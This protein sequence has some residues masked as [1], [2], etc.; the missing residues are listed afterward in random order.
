MFGLSQLYQLRGPG[1]PEPSPGILLPGG[2][3][4]DHGRSGEAAPD[5]GAPHRAGQRLRH[6]HEGPGAA[7]RRQHPGRGPVGPRP[8]GG[9][10]HLHAPAGEDRG[11]ALRGEEAREAFPRPTCPWTG[12]P[13]CPTTTWPIPPRS[14]TSTAACPVRSAWQSRAR[15]GTRWSTASAAPPPEVPAPGRRP[16]PP[17]RPGAG[18]RADQHRARPGALTFR[19]DVVPRLTALQNAM[20]GSQVEVEVRRMD[21]LSLVLHRLG[22]AG[23][24]SAV[25]EAMDRMTDDGARGR[26]TSHG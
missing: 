7:G 5:P 11:P 25:A 19:R 24:S 20:H 4:G 15:S 22:T 9:D 1:G 10:R 18:R 21:P 26:S 8:R 13:T 6:R 23:L 17:P 14:S 2:P 12:R 3:R 16:A